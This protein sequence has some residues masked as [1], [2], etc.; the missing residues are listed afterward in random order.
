MTIT[1]MLSSYVRLVDCYG[2]NDFDS[3]KVQSRWIH[4][5]LPYFVECRRNSDLWFFVGFFFL[6]TSFEIRFKQKSSLHVCSFIK[7]RIGECRV[8]REKIKSANWL[9]WITCHIK[10]ATRKQWFVSGGINRR[11]IRSIFRANSPADRKSV[12]IFDIATEG[13]LTWWTR[14]DCD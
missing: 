6:T 12:W 13:K 9:R 14:F 1:A 10:W 8:F 7:K 11:K 4:A 2:C 3:S 5:D